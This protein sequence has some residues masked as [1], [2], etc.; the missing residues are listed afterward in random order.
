M[1]LSVVCDVLMF[2][3]GQAT[4]AVPQWLE[5]SL[6]QDDIRALENAGSRAC[7]GPVNRDCRLFLACKD[8][9]ST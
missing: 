6:Q 9:C 7:A 8:S 2:P 5:S 4:E 1:L 3:F